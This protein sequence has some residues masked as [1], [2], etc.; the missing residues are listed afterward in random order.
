MAA[1]DLYLFSGIPGVGKTKLAQQLAAHLGL[2]YLRID[3][4]EQGL[5]DC[6]LE[7]E[8][9]GYRLAYRLAA[10][11]LLL[12]RGVVADSCNP[13]AATRR[14]WWLV[15]QACSVRA[16]DIEVVCSDPREHQCRVENRTVS[17][18]GLKPPTWAQV[19][20]RDHEPWPGDRERI[21]IDTAG[22]PLSQSFSELLHLL[23]RP[24][25]VP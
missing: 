7:V 4:I 18:P 12:G 11:N 1:T 8:T 13:V 25:A 23:D 2:V 6:G 22:Q 16:I 20:A 9:E 21:R 14:A 3:T 15:A 10:D 19:M 24:A 5:R 17:V